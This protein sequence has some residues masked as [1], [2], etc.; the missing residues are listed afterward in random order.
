MSSTYTLTH[1][2]QRMPPKMKQKAN[3]K[4]A[5]NRELF[6]MCRCVYA[7]DFVYHFHSTLTFRLQ[8]VAKYYAYYFDCLPSYS[9]Y[10]TI[11]ITCIILL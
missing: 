6:A 2:T 8:V 4:R 1:T 7:I 10:Y 9:Y 3:T 11:L 5:N